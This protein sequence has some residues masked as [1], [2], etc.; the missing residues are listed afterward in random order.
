MIAR[1]IIFIS[2]TQG[3]TEGQKIIHNPETLGPF[4]QI[5]GV[6]T[7]GD[8]VDFFRHVGEPFTG[9]LIPENDPRNLKALLIPKIMPVKDKF[10]VV[11]CR[12]YD[13]PAVSE[14]TASDETLPDGVEPYYL[15]ANTGP[16]WMCGGVMSRPFITT[17]Q[18]SGVFAISSI[19]SSSVYGKSVFTRQMSFRKVHHVFAVLEGVLAIRVKGDEGKH[20]I[21]EGET[22][23]IP[24]G[25][26]FSLEFESKYVRVWSF[27][28][29]DGVESLVHR[30]GSTIEG[31]VLPDEANKW[32]ES[33][34]RE[35][36]E[37]LNIDLES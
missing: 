23:M 36:C 5:Y 20:L 13:P 9:L 30:L 27:A 17:K 18:N 12:D 29:G 32:D 7:P 6:I 25:Q 8:W 33:K 1:A 16:R 2:A 14:W 3:L 34:L 21:R 4:T 31:F 28:S 26:A 15:K 35:A 37:D 22:A 24:A 11:F 10:D 19:E